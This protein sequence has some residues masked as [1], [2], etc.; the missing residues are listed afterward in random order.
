MPESL[1]RFWEDLLLFVEEGKVIPVIGPELVTVEEDGTSIPLYHWLAR[2][3][4][5][6]IDLPFSDLPDPFDLND[7]VAQ[8]IHL[9]RS[10][11]AQAHSLRKPYPVLTQALTIYLYVLK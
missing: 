4:A 8:S 3:L 5:E 7:V 11:R 6:R 10:V 2:S 1:E 9:G